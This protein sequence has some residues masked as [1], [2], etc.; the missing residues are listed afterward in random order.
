MNPE[1]PIAI[2][3]SGVGGLTVFRAVR[4]RL[5][6]EHLIYFGDTAH[7]PYGTRSPA[8]VSRLVRA[9][10]DF[11]VRK[12]IKCLVVACNTAS[13]VALGFLRRELPVPVIGVIEP[14]VR[15]ALARTSNG[16][17]GVVGTR[18]T[19]ASGAY[20]RRL[21]E[22]GH[23]IRVFPQ[24][25]PLFVPIAEEGWMGHQIARLAAREYLTGLRKACVDT[26]I[27]GCTHY[28]L[29]K[30]AIGSTMGPGVELVDSAEVVAG[31]LARQLEKM[32]LVRKNGVRGRETFFLTDTGGSFRSVAERF[33][34]RPIGRMVKVRVTVSVSRDISGGRP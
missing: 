26:V 14:G 33:L 20:Q 27:L 25:C 17:V 21:K 11:L 18:T 15:E 4:A 29:L 12:G 1:K 30:R 5:P 24:A 32:H 13:A 6:R 9:H 8:T 28:P 19:I 23:K 16:R 22:G 2:F 7:V 31:E 3:D 10:A 34:G